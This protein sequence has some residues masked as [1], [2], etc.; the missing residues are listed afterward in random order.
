MARYG[1]D[2]KDATRR[3]LI[4]AAGR[5]F[6]DDGIDGAGISAVVAE[7]GL[8]NGAFYGH[9]ESK[10]DLVACVVGDQLARQVDVVEALPPGLD[11]ID[12][13]LRDYLSPAHRDDRAGG[14]PSAALLDEIGRRDLGT[15]EAYTHGARSMIGAITRRLEEAGIPG[16]PDRAVGMF[17][18]LVGSLQLARAVTDPELADRVLADAYRT[19]LTLATADLG[20]QQHQPDQPR[21]EQP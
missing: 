10:D 21:Q 14:C 3:R 5:R 15:R 19:A 6:K 20:P 18:L 17:T 1:P 2:H 13:Y 4:E 7:A 11:A 16:A 8:T 9:F 12:R